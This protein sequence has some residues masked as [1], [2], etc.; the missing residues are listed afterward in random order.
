MANAPFFGY[1][2]K[3]GYRNAKGSS[4]TLGIQSFIQQLNLRNSIV[5]QVIAR[6]WHNSR[7]RKVGTLIWLTLN[8]GLPVGTWLQ[9]MGT[10]PSCKVC[11][12]R[13][14]ESPQHCLL[15]CPPAQR[16]WK[17]FKRIWEDWKALEDF[18]PTWP[19]IL[20]GEAIFEREDDPP[21]L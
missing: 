11:D 14:T 15:N 20:L 18:L 13:T 10:P 5:L 12:S 3:K 6:M 7:P 2:A 17:A 4:H 1:S 21:G 8:R 9:Q 16:A 19:F